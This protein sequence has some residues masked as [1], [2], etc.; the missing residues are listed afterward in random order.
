MNQSTADS[1]DGE[2]V[3]KHAAQGVLGF[4]IVN[5]RQ[6]NS[7]LSYGVKRGELFYMKILP[8]VVANASASE[9]G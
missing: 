8:A 2:E 4:F 9:G 3:G 7:S 6:S 1:A 5:W